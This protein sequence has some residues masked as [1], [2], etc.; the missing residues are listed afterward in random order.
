M[1][2]AEDRAGKEAVL[3]AEVDAASRT[4]AHESGGST[5]HCA[6]HIGPEAR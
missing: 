6:T 3:N 4:F 1:S 2:S 5:S